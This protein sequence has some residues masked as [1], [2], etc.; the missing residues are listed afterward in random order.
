[1]PRSLNSSCCLD[2]R[3]HN[4]GRAASLHDDDFLDQLTELSPTGFDS[5]NSFHDDDPLVS[6]QNL[7]LLA[8][9]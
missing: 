9:L 3:V 8:S 6:A 4:V 5:D 1:M 7:A 2:F